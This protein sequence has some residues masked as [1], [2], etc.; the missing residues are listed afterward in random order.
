GDAAVML[1]DKDL[2]TIAELIDV[3]ARE[4]PLRTELARRGEMRL[5]AFAP[6]RT[7]QAVRE[8]FE[9]LL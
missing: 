4:Q 5:A 3:C 1:D 6:D 2:P 8:L 9:S 7:E